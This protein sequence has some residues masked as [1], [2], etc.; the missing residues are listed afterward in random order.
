MNAKRKGERGNLKLKFLSEEN[1]SGRLDRNHHLPRLFHVDIKPIYDPLGFAD[2]RYVP[3]F[4]VWRYSNQ[5][6]FETFITS[7]DE[8]K[9]RQASK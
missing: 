9:V 4:D 3:S 6:M 1:S 2:A 8:V 7:Q 5:S